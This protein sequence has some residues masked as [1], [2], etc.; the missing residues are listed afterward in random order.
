M[1]YAEGD[2]I[3][4]IRAMTTILEPIVPHLAIVPEVRMAGQWLGEFRK[5]NPVRDAYTEVMRKVIR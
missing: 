3:D 5:G 2:A 1:S 4:Q